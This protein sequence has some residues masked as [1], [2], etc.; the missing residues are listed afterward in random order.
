MC[1]L[2][3]KVEEAAVE[4]EV[5]LEAR[6]VAVTQVR[7]SSAQQTAQALRSAQSRINT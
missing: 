7:G 1:G 4:P 5:G 6:E 3:S 2:G